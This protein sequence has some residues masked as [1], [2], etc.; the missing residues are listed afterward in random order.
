[1]IAKFKSFMIQR[2]NKEKS[3]FIT[4]FVF[5]LSLSVFGQ[6]LP[7]HSQYVYNPLVIHML[8]TYFYLNIKYITLFFACCIELFG[9]LYIFYL[10][11][12]QFYWTI[13]RQ[14]VI[15]KRTYQPS[16]RKRKNKHGF[17][18]RKSTVGGKKVL[19]SRMKK[20][21]KRLTVSS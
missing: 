20:G 16:N 5:F 17:M 15:M 21:R 2:S 8:L 19:S 12:K 11:Y 9:L 6:Q 18:K 1:M 14:Y 3:I 4:F 7:L 13:F 10:F